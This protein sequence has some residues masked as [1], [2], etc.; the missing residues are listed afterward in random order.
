MWP[1]AL[2]LAPDNHLSFSSVWSLLS[3]LGHESFSTMSNSNPP[4]FHS[5]TLR[6]L[7]IPGDISVATTGE[8]VLP[9]SSELSLGMLLNILQRRL[10]T[11][12]QQCQGWQTPLYILC[13]KY[14]KVILMF[15]IGSRQRSYRSFPFVY[16]GPTVWN[17]SNL[18]FVDHLET[19]KTK[20]KDC[21]LHEPFLDLLGQSYY[22]SWY[23]S[24]S[25]LLVFPH[26]NTQHNGLWLSSD[27]S[28]SP[29]GLWALEE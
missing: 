1:T 11:N 20:L 12:Y 15:Y 19:S 28:A 29:I 21:L 14:A 25:I 4:R 16:G 24:V 23:S 27:L 6:H 7:E 26:C 9:T 2:W 18:S 3:S 13:S 17:G 22:T 8:Q 10:V 5:L